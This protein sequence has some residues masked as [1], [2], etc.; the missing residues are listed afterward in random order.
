MINFYYKLKIFF[1]YVLPLSIVLGC[2]FAIIISIV[3]NKIKKK[4]TKKKES[5]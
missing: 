2:I 3:K 5:K 4:F 1:E